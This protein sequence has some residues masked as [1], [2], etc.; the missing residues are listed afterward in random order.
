MGIVVAIR[1]NLWIPHKIAT[2]FI[3]NITEKFSQNSEFLVQIQQWR[4]FYGMFLPQ[5]CASNYTILCNWRRI[6]VKNSC[7]PCRTHQN[8]AE[9]FSQNTD[10][11]LKIQQWRTFVGCFLPQKC[12]SNY[13]ILCN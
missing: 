13:T 2:I 3:Q 5:N 8:I 9:K 6:C 11:L 4:D 12:G 7:V 1:Q 10:F